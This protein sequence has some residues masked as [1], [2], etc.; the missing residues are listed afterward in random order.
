MRPWTVNEDS[1]ARE[2]AARGWPIAEIAFHLNRSPAAV[3]AWL[4]R[5]PLA[6]RPF[7]RWE[8]QLLA[9]RWEESPPG[10]LARRLNRT[11]GEIIRRARELDL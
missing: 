9:E 11:E 8:D 5:R 4:K 10:K 2:H 1:Y 3:V 7:A 6:G